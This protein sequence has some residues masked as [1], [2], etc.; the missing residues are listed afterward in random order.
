MKKI[1]IL[2]TVSALLASQLGVLANAQTLLPGTDELNSTAG[3]NLIL[4]D[5]VEIPNAGLPDI[6]PLPDSGLTEVTLPDVTLPEATLPEVTSPEATL[7]ETEPEASESAEVVPDNKTGEL[8]IAFDGVISDSVIPVLVDGITYVPFRA[9]C[10]AA[11]DNAEITWDDESS[12][13]FCDSETLD[14]TAPY[15][16]NYI[17]ANGR[18]ICRDEKN[19][20]LEDTLYVPARSMAAALNSE[21]EW[22]ADE[23]CVNLIS[24]ED[25]IIPGSEFYNQTDLLWLA[26]IINAESRYEPLLGKI[27]VGNVVLNR[28]ASADFPDTV[29]DVIF[30]CRYSTIQFYPITSPVI[31]NT[32]SDESI[33]AAKACLE[34][35]TVSDSAL[36]FM[37]EK[38]ATT[39][40]ISRNRDFVFK[41]GNHSFYA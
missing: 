29:Y 14:I 40:W 4:P 17:I 25:M 13:S 30:D 22:I 26:R 20:T 1:L 34:G 19:V 16:Q 3:A 8:V 31:Y 18:V 10:T 36:Y 21:V 27:A 39:T 12:T 28:V 32:P 2:L 5:T 41:I 38:T 7:P 9:F 35:Y 6:A 37:N 33:I 11:V 23:L 15:D 24:G